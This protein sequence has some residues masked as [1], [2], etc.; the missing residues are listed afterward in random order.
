MTRPFG[1]FVTILILIFLLSGCSSFNCTRLENLLGGDVNL[2]TLAEKITDNLVEDALPPLI[3]R[4]PD[5]PILTST[6]VCNDNLEETSRFGRLL[7]EYIGARL[8]QLGY[9]VREIK[10][11]DTMQINP[12][13]GEKM[14]SRD[15]SQITADQ[16]A[17]ATLVGT[18]SLNNRT[19]YISTRL[20]NPVNKNILSA[21]SYRLC[22]DDNLLAMFGLQREMEDKET[23]EAPSKSILNKIF[24]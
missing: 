24:Y 4:H 3:P 17:Q 1:S 5:L 21:H 14:L 20:V 16:P 19:L 15:L 12:G 18:Y 13:S 6:F 8:V 9:T 2:I 22:M 10:L 7:Q 11:R 23:I